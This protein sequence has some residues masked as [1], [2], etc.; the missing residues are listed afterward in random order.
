MK[1]K[2][3]FSKTKSVY[4]IT[5]E[6][7]IAY[8]NEG[9]FFHGAALAYYALFSLF[10]LMYLSLSIFSRFISQQKII[11]IIEYVLI[12]KIGIKEVD[13]IMLHISDYNLSGGNLWYETISFLMLIFISSSFFVSLRRSINE[14]FGFDSDEIK[15]KSIA[16]SGLIRLFYVL[17][18]GACSA[19]IISLYLFQ[20]ISFSWLS[21]YLSSNEFVH[22]SV[23]YLL[24][25]SLSLL[26]NYLIFLFVFKFMHD[27][28][29]SWKVASKGAWVTSFLLFIGQLIIKYYLNNYFFLGSAEI[30]GSLFIFLAWVHFSSQIIFIGAK[31]CSIYASRIKDPIIIK[32]P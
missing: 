25:Y 29:V 16:K 15:K 4:S 22:S 3:L 12:N 30:V 2:K 9:A 32:I 20:F 28:I 7:V 24:D 10:P 5:K 19:L 6:T 21:N 13:G 14:Y 26:T 17:F 1:K 31:F 23:G 27:G 8:I 18:I 11:S